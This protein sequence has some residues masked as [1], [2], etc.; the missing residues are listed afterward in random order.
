MTIEDIRK[1]S[2]VQ[3]WFLLEDL[4]ETTKN[5]YLQGLKDYMVYSG[6]NPSDIL[7]EAEE[8][9]KKPPRERSLRK[10][11]GGFRQWLQ[12]QGKAPY[13]VKGRVTAMKSFFAAFE[14]DVPRQKKKDRTV[15]LEENEPIPTQKDL[16]EILSI[17]DPLERALVLVGASS[18][19]AAA[20]ISNLKVSTFK[21]GLDE[22]SKITALKLR[23]GKTGGKFFVTFLTPEATKAVQD[24]LDFR[25]HPHDSNTT[26]T[27]QQLEKQAVHDSKDFLFCIRK[28]P[29]IYL[30]SHDENLRK[31]DTNGIMKIYRRLSEQAGKNTVKNNWN[32]IRS[33]NIR[34]FYNS[35][36]LN[37]GAD[38][39]FVEFT[40]GHALD[41][42]RAA[43]FRAQPEKLR[44]IYK[45]YVDILTITKEEV[46]KTT[47]FKILQEEVKRLT[48]EN[49]ALKLNNPEN[50]A[51]RQLKKEV[52][53]LRKAQKE[54]EE[55][56]KE[57]EP[58]LEKE[59][60]WINDIN[61][62]IDW[63]NDEAVDAY[64][65][66]Q[67]NNTPAEI[68]QHRQNLKDDPEYRENFETV[69]G[70]RAEKREREL[71]KKIIKTL[72]EQL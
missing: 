60:A 48:D 47:E 7:K 15:T 9:L 12:D 55:L 28:V 56:R 71:E 16:M 25:N 52:E 44:E 36:M 39:F 57:F 32:L 29:K 67:L 27:M 45:K 46:Q 6:K 21:D 61:K 20:E 59:K 13:T 38:S 34:K 19:L 1:D 8:D 35:T 11:L 65:E 63:A 10:Q 3:D 68:T 23:R 51:L 42:T 33:H 26:R 2:T 49:E 50:E 30:E 22:E 24:Y 4:K 31:M 64:I 58:I 17:A 72:A 5:A 18:G 53:E 70:V 43:Y 14:I 69:T 37:A 62:T 66:S 54:K 40:M 41:E